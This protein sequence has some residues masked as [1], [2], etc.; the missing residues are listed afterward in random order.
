MVYHTDPRDSAA[1]RPCML[2]CND[3]VKLVSFLPFHI[4]LICA[5][6]GLGG[7]TRQMGEG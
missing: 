2:T 7:S 3:M 6:F 5:I 1:N 4:V